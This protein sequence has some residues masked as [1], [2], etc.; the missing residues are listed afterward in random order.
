MSTTL[1]EG[2]RSKQKLYRR[3]EIAMGNFFKGLLIF[4]VLYFLT[5][6]FLFFIGSIYSAYM[7]AII[8]SVA[9]IDILAIY[10]MLNVL[11]KRLH[12]FEY[13]RTKKSMFLQFVMFQV[14]CVMNIV[15]SV[16]MISKYRL[17]LEK[18]HKTTLP[19]T[20]FQYFRYMCQWEENFT[21]TRI[22]AAGLF[23]QYKLSIPGVIT[24]LV[25]VKVKSSKDILQGIS[26]LDHL[27]KVSVFQK[28]RSKEAEQQKE[29]LLSVLES[30][31]RNSMVS[32]ELNRE[33]LWESI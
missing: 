13:Q 12:H 19:M 20:E 29:E 18:Y 33:S 15:Y 27:L 28:F 4:M 11:M 17:I 23:I 32:E 22:A 10:V 24:A 25:I 31:V 26:K 30:T 3:A 14:V 5:A 2:I 8:F 9:S 21:V 7:L 1:V 16:L 6:Y